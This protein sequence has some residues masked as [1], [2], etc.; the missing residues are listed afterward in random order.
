[1]NYAGS[2]TLLDDDGN[3]VFQRELTP[4]EIIAELLAAI[5][6]EAD[7]ESEPEEEPIAAVLPSSARQP[8][9]EKPARRCGSCGRPGHSRR[10]CSTG[11]AAP[12]VD[13]EVE[14]QPYRG[15]SKADSLTL[16]QFQMV[17][18]SRENDLKFSSSVCADKLGVDLREVN[19]AILTGSW[20]KYQDS[21]RTTL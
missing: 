13:T 3:I 2:F 6:D 18:D 19:R 10:T 21:Y 11:G 5:P 7:T 14:E 15:E 12:L 8:K 17:V 20:E 1:M 4:D 9:S 16:G